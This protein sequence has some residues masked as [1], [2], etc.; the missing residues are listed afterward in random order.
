[1]AM[2]KPALPVFFSSPISVPIPALNMI[3]ITPSSAT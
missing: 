2:I 3:T 1:M